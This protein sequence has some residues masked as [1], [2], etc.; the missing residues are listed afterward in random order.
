[1]SQMSPVLVTGGGCALGYLQD[2]FDALC[3][4]V[5]LCERAGPFF[6]PLSFFWFFFFSF[7]VAH[8]FFFGTFLARFVLECV[9]E[10]GPALLSGP[11]L[12]GASPFELEVRPIRTRTR[13]FTNHATPCPTAPPRPVSP[14]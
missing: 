8:W 1:M 10:K 6:R 12:F 9:C 2:V 7:C 13:P 14:N 3:S 5:R 11:S 4:Q